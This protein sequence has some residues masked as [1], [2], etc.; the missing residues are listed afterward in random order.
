MA[1]TLGHAS[2]STVQGWWVR[3]TVPSKRIAQVLIVASREGIPLEVEEFFHPRELSSSKLSASDRDPEP[4]TAV[5]VGKGS[6][7]KIDRHS[8]GLKVRVP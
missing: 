3:D 4:A 6:L 8:G 7:S 1:R 2:Q 5:A